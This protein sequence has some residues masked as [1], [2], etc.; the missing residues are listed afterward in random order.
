MKIRYQLPLIVVSTLL[1]VSCQNYTG[2]HDSHLVEVDTLQIGDLERIVSI[3]SALL[4]EPREIVS[5][6]D[7]QLA[8]YDHAYKK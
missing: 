7:Q 3:E 4:G 8:V 6:D 2:Q 1:L 5:I